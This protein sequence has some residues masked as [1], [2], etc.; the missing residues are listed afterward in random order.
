MMIQ[1]VLFSDNKPVQAALPKYYVDSQLTRVKSFAKL[2]TQLF[3]S[4]DL[5]KTEYNR[6]PP[7]FILQKNRRIFSILFI[8]LLDIFDLFSLILFCRC[9]LISWSSQLYD[10]LDVINSTFGLTQSENLCTII[11]VSSFVFI[12]AFSSN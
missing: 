7:C 10:F 12:F 5:L 11:S 3:E 9:V 6:R 8:Q 2:C 4:H 1:K